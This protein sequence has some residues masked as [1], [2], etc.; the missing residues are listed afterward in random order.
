MKLRFRF[1]VAEIR[2]EFLV[3]LLHL[4]DQRGV[5]LFL[6]EFL[7]GQKVVVLLFKIQHEGLCVLQARQLGSDRLR[8]FR[9]VPKVRF[10]GLG[11]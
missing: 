4:S 2:F 7:V 3:A 9:I 5:V 1:E 10:R 11:F 6:E 8:G